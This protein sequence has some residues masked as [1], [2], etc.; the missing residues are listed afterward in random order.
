MF[1]FN[2]FTEKANRA[3]NKS[4]A[5][6]S[7]LGHTC[8]GSE[9][10]LYGL[11]SEEGSAAATLLSRSRITPERVEEKLRN[12]FGAGVK[13]TLTPND[14]TP[15]SRKLLESAL[16]RAQSEQNTVGTEHILLAIL[17]DE[18]CYA[19]MLLREMG[20]N[21]SDLYLS[22]VREL[23]GG[24]G[25]PS[26]FSAPG[27]HPSEEVPPPKPREKEKSR[28]VLRQF[29]R[30]LT[31]LAEQGKLDPVIG[32]QEE[33]ARTVEILAR[34]TKN[35]PCLIGEPGVGKTAVAE[36]LAQ[37]IIAGE[38]PEMLR[39]KRLV[40]LDLTAMLAGAK[41]RGDFEERL[42]RV[43]DEVS[44]RRNV[45]LFIDELHNIIGAGAAE[46]AIDAANILKPPLAR[47]EI[48][49][50]GA[51]TIAE[52]RRYIEKDSAL[53]RR[54]QPIT[55]EEPTREQAVLIL[56]GLR[57][58]YEAHHR[59]QITSEA[60]KAA[61]ELSSRYLTDRFL[62][63]KAIDLM[64]EA[65]SCVRIRSSAASSE[66]RRITE[67]IRTV[68]KEKNKAISKLKFEIASE[69]RL[70]EKELQTRY[71]EQTR[72]WKSQLGSSK[73]LV[74]PDD[75][76]EIV[77]RWSKIPVQQVT[78][79]ESHR[80]LQL[81]NDL[82]K[83]VIG[84]QEAVERICAAIRRGRL[85]LKDPNRPN[86]SFL[87]LGPTGVGKTEVSKALAEVLFGSETEMI[88]LDMSEYMEK[89]TVARLIGSPPGYVGYGEGGQLTERVRRKPYS[90]VLFDEVE[91]AHP[92]V[93][94]ILLQILED[95]FLTDSQGRRVNFREC[96]LIL[97]SNIGAQF[98]TEN[99]ALG[100][101]AL[102]EEDSRAREKTDVLSELKRRFSPEL[103]NRMDEIVVFHKLAPEALRTIARNMLSSLSERAKTL[104]I[105]F[106]YTDAAVEE[107]ARLGYKPEYGARPLRRVVTSKV[108]D[109]MSR[110]LLETD[111]PVENR[112]VLD[113]QNGQFLLL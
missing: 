111:T 5:M 50:I 90:I 75:I 58:K 113:V 77:A 83:R 16:A 55:L 23:A 107:I 112:F 91:K 94:H 6:A 85:G 10:F 84:Q 59:V 106:S 35:N 49:L 56:E 97:T 24:E 104:H 27:S 93:L 37:R 71:Q 57:E 73:P 76:A 82:Q 44:A 26:S 42:K 7:I 60:I 46:G 2:G 12:T 20:V 19:V 108:E 89:H 38:V 36:G 69:Y 11:A 87:F 105:D 61:V 41:Y 3:L 17:K 34:R 1:I 64:D 100:F 102:S 81:E 14:I 86:G 95:G 28:G 96:I 109:L 8:V 4:I 47:G 21:P 40:S 92:D 13:N 68:Q 80:L 110:K 25:E 51:T 54:F 30:D 74:G 43:L 18:S 70:E 79:K 72:L 33:I 101:G 31:E 53:E 98:L 52:Y 22:C 48:Q 15:R 45:I 103:L 88:R 66:M 32:R 99:K 9:H 63:D 39:E 62:P 67:E 65:S 29:G 78:M